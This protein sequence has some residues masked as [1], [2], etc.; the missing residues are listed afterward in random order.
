ME[1]MKNDRCFVCGPNNDAGLRAVFQRDDQRHLAFGR[2]CLAEPFQGWRGRVHG[3]VLAALLDEAC[4]YA[5]LG[6]G[7][8]PVTADLQVRYLLPVPCGCEVTLFGEVVEWRKKLVKAHSRLVLD[9][10]IHAEG[11]ARIILMR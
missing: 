3:G 7:G 11:Q 9:G 6:L 2:L 8:N 10:R 1:L 5:S 4:I